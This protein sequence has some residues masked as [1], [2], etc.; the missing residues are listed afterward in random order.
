MWSDPMFLHGTDYNPEQW[1]DYPEIFEQDIQLM[2]EADCN[3]MSVGIFSWAKIETEEGVY[4]FEWLDKII[5]NLYDNGICTV[6]DKPS[7]VRPTWISHKYLEV[8]RVGWNR[9]ITG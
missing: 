3:V 8:L 5:N 2:K 7:G 1:L 9:V 6:L 4:N